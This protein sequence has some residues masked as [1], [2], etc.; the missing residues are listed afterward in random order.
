M[1]INYIKSMENFDQKEFNSGERIYVSYEELKKNER[2]FKEHLD[3][4]NFALKFLT[5]KEI[6]IDAACGSG[7]GSEILSPGAKKVIGLEINDHAIKY[8][9]EHHSKNNIEFYKADLN[10]KINLPDNY[11]DVIVSFETLEHIA[12]QENILREF[13]RLLK[14]AGFLII[15]TPDKNLISGGLESDNPFHIKELT[16]IEFI[17]FLKRFFVIE[18]LFG[19]TKLK[20][21]PSWKKC[22]KKFRNISFLRKIKQYF[23]KIV[24]FERLFHRHF[25]SEEYIP[26]QVVDFESPNQFYV[27]IAVCKN[28]K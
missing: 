28:A 18:G 10:E 14:P 8:A 6:I 19:Q 16:K 20:K 17:N 15:S 23:A 13:K 27:L 4:Y 26:I 9:K 3:R 2:G 24:G 7:Y 21:L 25:A 11:S 12:N 1:G 5:G 22:L